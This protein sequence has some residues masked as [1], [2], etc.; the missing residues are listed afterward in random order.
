MGLGDNDFTTGSDHFHFGGVYNDPRGLSD[1]DR[2]ER[3]SRLKVQS[4]L[5]AAWLDIDKL[6]GKITS[7]AD[8]NLDSTISSFQKN[9]ADLER[10]LDSARSNAEMA[11]SES[12]LIQVNRFIQEQFIE[13]QKIKMTLGFLRGLK[14]YELNQL[15]AAKM[16]FGK[17]ATAKAD[18]E[19][20][21]VKYPLTF[22]E[23]KYVFKDQLIVDEIDPVFTTLNDVVTSII[24]G[25][26]AQSDLRAAGADLSSK[27]DE[28]STP[29]PCV[30]PLLGGTML[31]HDFLDSGNFDF[32][33]IK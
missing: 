22:S 16:E 5:F 8:V 2:L 15:E 9:L 6:V 27:L 28:V 13:C 33:V 30:N 12:V 4:D 23:S 19:Q 20:L 32:E 26:I 21:H 10:R 29:K 3:I 24:Y 14:F 7:G 31:T 17:I 11:V 25:K 18:A 1:G